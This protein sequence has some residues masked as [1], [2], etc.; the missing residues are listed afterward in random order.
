MT[1]NVM[2]HD[3]EKTIDDKITINETNNETIKNTSEKK[4]LKFMEEKVNPYYWEDVPNHICDIQGNICSIQL[5]L[6]SC[7]AKYQMISHVEKHGKLSN[8]FLEDEIYLRYME[9]IRNTV[10]YEEY[11]NICRIGR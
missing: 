3:D 4:I 9:M 6:V 8:E 1:N 7:D 2:K 5:G 10:V 11:C